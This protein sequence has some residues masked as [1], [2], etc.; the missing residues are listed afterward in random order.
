[1][2]RENGTI[3]KHRN[4]GTVYKTVVGRYLIVFTYSINKC[5]LSSSIDSGIIEENIRL[6]FIS[7]DRASA[8]SIRV[9]IYTP[10]GGGVRPVDFPFNV[11]VTC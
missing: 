2:V 8:T 1:M 7:I 5:A 10:S 4:A 9:N 6:G 3:V 11:V